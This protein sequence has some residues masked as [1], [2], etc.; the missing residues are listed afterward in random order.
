[1]HLLVVVE[2]RFMV[3]RIPW[4]ATCRHDEGVY[5]DMYTSASGWCVE[6]IASVKRFSTLLSALTGITVL[7][8]VVKEGTQVR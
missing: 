5:P 6:L 7:W 8:P 2:G 1:M 3:N 4:G